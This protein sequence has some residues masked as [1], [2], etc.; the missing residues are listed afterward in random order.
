M[1]SISISSPLNVKKKKKVETKLHENK[2]Q[3]HAHN[4]HTKDKGE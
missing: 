4:E 3:S 1:F 2:Y